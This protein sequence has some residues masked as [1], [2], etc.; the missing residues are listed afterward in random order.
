MSDGVGSLGDA[1]ASGAFGHVPV[2]AVVQAE[3]IGVGVGADGQLGL[4]IRGAFGHGV[5]VAGN[6]HVMLQRRSLGA[7]TGRFWT[8]QEA[9]HRR[10]GQSGGWPEA[11]LV[12]HLRGWQQGNDTLG[13]EVALAGVAGAHVPVV[14]DQF[15]DAEVN[16][17]AGGDGTAAPVPAADGPVGPPLQHLIQ[18]LVPVLEV[19][20]QVVAPLIT[21]LHVAGGV[22]LL[23]LVR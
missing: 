7:V 23:H 21:G 6:H 3:Q 18:L 1:D 13:V 2:H 16:V 14:D 22:G 20:Q 8:N 5:A 15:L 4:P 10:R 12:P 17:A 19:D 11:E 9:V